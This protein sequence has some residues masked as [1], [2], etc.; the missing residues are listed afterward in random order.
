MTRPAASR[1]LSFRVVVAAGV[2]L[3]LSLGA[4]LALPSAAVAADGPSWSVSPAVTDD[5]ERRAN[6]DYVLDPGET[7]TDAFTVRNDGAAE[8]TLAVYAADAFTTREGTID[9][10]PAGEVSVDAGTWVRFPSG[11][12]TL[13]PGQSEDV[14]FTLTVPG[15]ARPGDHP[16]GVVASLVSD[17]PDAQV[18][19]DRRLGSRMHIRIAGDLSPSVNISDPTVA[20][21]GSLNPLAFGDLEVSYRVENTG[22]TRITGLAATR[23][24]GPLGIDA[25]STGEQQLPEVLPGSSIDVQQRLTGVAAVFWLTGAVEVAPSSVG[26]GAAALDAVTLDFGT[27]AVP[28]V[29]LAIL[30]LVAAVVVTVVVVLRRRARRAESAGASVSSSSS[31]TA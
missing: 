22:N 23:A 16:A 27:P 6:F 12:V 8:L 21:T 24:G 9:L 13:Q 30:V 2:S 28:V 17:D 18:Q 19:L 25:G 20:F 3:A 15:D 10:L 7:L 11:S 4:A 5:G 29:L 31:S 14:P 1:P 26:L